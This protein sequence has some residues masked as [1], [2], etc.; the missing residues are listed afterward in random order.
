MNLTQIIHT[1]QSLSIQFN[2][3]VCT[4]KLYRC[5][6]KYFDF[7]SAVEMVV[8]GLMHH[9]KEEK[10]KDLLQRWKGPSSRMNKFSSSI[11]YTVRQHWQCI[12]II[13][14]K[15]KPPLC[16]LTGCLYIRWACMHLTK[17]FLLVTRC[18]EQMSALSFHIL[19]S[20]ILLNGCW[21]SIPAFLCLAD[22][23]ACQ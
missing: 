14:N 22:K 20:C 1:R 10:M 16:L 3:N 21:L 4:I 5:T 19:F 11:Q 6:I 13:H 2:Y 12:I 23:G 8:K 7:L 18:R 17:L 15:I 9:G